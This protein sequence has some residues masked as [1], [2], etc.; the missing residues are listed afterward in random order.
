M[1]AHVEL[2]EDQERIVL[3]LTRQELLLLTGAVN[4]AIEAVEDWEFSTRLG[5][6]EGEA[7]ELRSDLRRS[8]RS[9]RRPRAE[10]VISRAVGPGPL[11]LGWQPQVHSVYRA[12]NG[13]GGGSHTGT[14]PNLTSA[15]L[16]PLG[17]HGVPKDVLLKLAGFGYRAG[18]S[19]PLGARRP[20]R[21]LR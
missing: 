9:C 3:S 2:L 19:S 20:L 5:A 16:L 12:F 11:Q 7:R 4:E 15:D 21:L 18:S 17:S 8:S 6:E 13:W 14:V 10:L 1:E